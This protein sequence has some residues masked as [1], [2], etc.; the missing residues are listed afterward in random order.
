[1]SIT[2]MNF[3]AIGAIGGGGG[4]GGG[5][6]GPTTGCGGRGGGGGGFTLTRKMSRGASLVGSG[7]S[8][9]SASRCTCGASCAAAD[10]RDGDG[11][12]LP[13]LLSSLLD[14]TVTAADGWAGSDSIRY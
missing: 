11:W 4:G 14:A 2:P 9:S 5:R 3:S 8:P 10:V 6:F 1:M 7:R 13:A 12:L